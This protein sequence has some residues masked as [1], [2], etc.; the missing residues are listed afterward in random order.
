MNKR[1]RNEY[2]Q[3]NN[4]D[5]DMDN[6]KD[7]EQGFPQYQ[8]PKRRRHV[9]L[10]MPLGLSTEDF[11]SL[12]SPGQEEPLDLAYSSYG[13]GDADSGWTTDDDCVLVQMVLEK[14]KLSNRQWNDCARVLG[15]DKASLGK[16][17]RL[18]VGEGNI[19]LRRGRRISRT[20]LDIRSW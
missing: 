7:S 8:T 5:T 3:E 19:G 13:D 16:R 12:D 15:R 2:E 20:D 14:L 6:D 17:W 9:P 11:V 4:D 10:A 18:L 1:R